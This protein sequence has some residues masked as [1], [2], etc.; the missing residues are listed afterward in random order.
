[1]PNVLLHWLHP[2]TCEKQVQCGVWGAQGQGECGPA[3]GWGRATSTDR[4]PPPAK[5]LL[6]RLCLYLPSPGL[7]YKEHHEGT[8]PT[9]DRGDPDGTLLSLAAQCLVRKTGAA[10][11]LISF[12]GMRIHCF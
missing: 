3:G 4:T 9:P 2:R 11:L 1:M 12:R 10:V 6:P 5:V 7:H 8:F